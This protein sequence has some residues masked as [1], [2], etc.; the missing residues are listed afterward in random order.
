MT[1][2]AIDSVLCSYNPATEELIQEYPC[3]NEIEFSTILEQVA[4]AQLK[5][6]RKSVE[7][8]ANL[9]LTLA[10]LLEETQTYAKLITLEMGKPIQE[11]KAEVEKC[12]VL[13]RYYA[14]NAGKFLADEPV[15][16]NGKRSYITFEPLGVILGIM[17]WN[18][19]F[20]QVFRFAVPALLAGNG[21]VLKHASN[22]TGCSLAIQELFQN[23]AF[24]ES[25]FRSVVLPGDQVEKLISHSLVS[26]VTLTG[27]EKA[28]MAVASQ[29]GRHLKKTVLELGGSDPFIVLK[30]AN[31][32]HCVKTAAKARLI[33]GGQSC[34]AAKR[35]LVEE[36]IQQAFAEK[37]VKEV[38]S[39][40]IG[41]MARNDIRLEVHDQ[42]MR[43]V[44]MG[45]QILTG[46][47][48]PA[49]KGFFYPV[50]ILKGVTPEMPVFQEE[51]FGPIFAITDVKDADHAVKLAN[52]SDYGLGGAVW[53]QNIKEGERL[54]REIQSG[55]VVV[56]GM[57]VSDP[58][59]PFGGIKKSGYGRELS[60]YGLRE[61]VNVKT[62]TLYP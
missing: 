62:I 38:S 60:Y 35:F 31:L 8:R 9:F 54:A 32:D 15:Q 2:R 11:S 21:A 57:T 58:A 17:P 55:T 27:S 7:E 1:N 3:H 50:T 61:F 52:Q 4:N 43:S 18:F 14:E 10:N 24:P 42:V 30:D 49:E 26:A 20:W 45:A 59:L 13:C 33:N 40:A 48:L 25:L 51:T 44:E 47:V 29:C 22:V 46:G 36:S 28:G 37:L 6:K 5:W 23:A 41:P 12:G 34:I 16:A 39:W 56:N 53:T 19:P